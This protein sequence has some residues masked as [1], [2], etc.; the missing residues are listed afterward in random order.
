[1]EVCEV[2]T[3]EEVGCVRV[4]G[5]GKCGRWGDGEVLDV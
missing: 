3:V 2:Y 5:G 4:V 1:M